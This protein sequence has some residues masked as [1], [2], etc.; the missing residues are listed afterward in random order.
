MIKSIIVKPVSSTCN[1]SCTYC[2]NRDGNR[3]KSSDY[4]SI[5]TIYNILNSLRANN[6][7]SIHFIWHG[8]E[9]LLRGIDFYN[10]F[11]EIVNSKQYSELFISNSVM[12]NGML[13]NDEWCKFFKKSNWK[14]GFSI[15]GP[16]Q[17]HDMC[18]I[19]SDGSGTHANVISAKQLAE[20]YELHPGMIAVLTD[21][22]I[23]YGAINLYNYLKDISKGFDISVGWN[24]N[25][26]NENMNHEKVISF[27]KDMIDEWWRQD[28][29]AIKIRYFTG[30]LNSV[31]GGSPHNC[32]FQNNC[33]SYI[34]IE[35]NGDIYPCG[36]F[37][38]LNEFCLGNINNND[39]ST[40]LK[41]KEREYYLKNASHKSSDCIKCKW[42]NKCNNGCNYER[43]LGNGKFSE[44]N[45]LCNIW[46]EMYEY[47]YYKVSCTKK[48]LQ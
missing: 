2:Y 11:M 40:A 13:I 4:I 28:D 36:K 44:K 16:E 18:R 31:T 29:P 47:M 6:I 23:N 48:I 35:S 5:N 9:P 7:K 30:L 20:K 24:L 45:P 33:G 27:L 42:R 39:M 22:S 21:H 8:G 3:I 14:I 26:M 46:Y 12:T 37:A 1:L 10:E 19:K 25:E 15:D 32:S 17:L 43:Y 34:A 38:G 41:S